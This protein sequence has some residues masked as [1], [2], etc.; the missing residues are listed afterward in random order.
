MKSKQALAQI[1]SVENIVHK[2]DFAHSY[3]MTTVLAITG[4]SNNHCI[5]K[6][7]GY[8]KPGTQTRYILHLCYISSV[9]I[10]TYIYATGVY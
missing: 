5:S 1:I 7:Y 8:V 10:S 2:N 4:L 6:T 3:N 9:N